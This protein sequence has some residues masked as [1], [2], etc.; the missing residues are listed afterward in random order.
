MLVSPF[1]VYDYEKT[2]NK[3]VHPLIEHE[4]GK[5]FSFK[6]LDRT[7]FADNVVRNLKKE[8]CS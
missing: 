4:M 6:K 3:W 8:K 2:S 5:F 1:L 7:S